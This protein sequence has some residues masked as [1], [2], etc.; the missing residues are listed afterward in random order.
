MDIN[1]VLEGTYAAGM[2]S[3]YILL[4]APLTLLQTLASVTAPSSSSSRRPTPTL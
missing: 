4:E 3:I 1:Q 2:L